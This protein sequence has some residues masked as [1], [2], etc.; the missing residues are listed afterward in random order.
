MINKFST[1]ESISSPVLV[2]C[3]HGVGAPKLRKLSDKLSAKLIDIIVHNEGSGSG[4]LNEKCGADYVK[5]QQKAPFGELLS[6]IKLL[7]ETVQDFK[8]FAI[9]KHRVKY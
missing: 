4:K 8:Y 6:V 2:D 3:A 9:N 1:Q 5:V 7:F